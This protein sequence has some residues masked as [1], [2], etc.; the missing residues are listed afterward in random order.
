M[1]VVDTSAL[2]DSLVGPRRSALRMRRFIEDG[3]RLVVPALVLY[4]WWRGPRSAEELA[5]QEALFPS[6][7]APPFGPEQAGLAARLYRDVRRPRGREVDLAIAAHAISRRA[8]LWTLNV[9]D[10]SDI[11]GL[12]MAS[13]LEARW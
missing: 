10:F 13:N 7:E 6:E 5:V 4:E 11:P 9:D 8:A 1:I 12:T 2:I 3:E